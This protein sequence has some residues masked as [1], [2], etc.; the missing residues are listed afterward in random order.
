PWKY[1]G[2]ITTAQRVMP[3]PVKLDVTVRTL[4]DAQK[5]MGSLNWVQS[6]LGLTTSQLQPLF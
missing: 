4:T 3:Q 5:L 6:Y 1:L 2:L